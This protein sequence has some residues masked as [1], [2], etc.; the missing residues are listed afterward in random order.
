MTQ[1]QEPAVQA[2]GKP[3][4]P[5]YKKWWIWVI[6]VV[7]I[8]GL[9]NLGGDKDEKPT[10]DPKPAATS[11]APKETEQAEA[12]EPSAEPEPEVTEEAPEPEPEPE[13]PTEFKS[14][15]KKAEN[16][17]DMMHM[18]KAGLYDQLTSEYGEKFSPEAGQYA[19]DNINADW[20]LNALK[21]AES[22]Q[23]MM[24]MSPSAIH[25]QLTSEHGEKFTKEQADY[26][27][28]NLK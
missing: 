23:E 10:A 12:P 8:A 27:I 2:A 15:L 19:I 28:A 11:D 6:A 13:V 9:A 22:Y 24:S 16:Y 5:W 25:D 7:V 17:S 4:K 1:I 14:A 26:A 20:N 3:K 21:K 18:S